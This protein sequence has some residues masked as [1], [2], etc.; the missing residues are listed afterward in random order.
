MTEKI[1]KELDDY[2][3]KL[4]GNS[5]EGMNK[6]Y[7]YIQ[8]TDMLLAMEKI[9]PGM[10]IGMEDEESLLHVKKAYL[11]KEEIPEK[12]PSK[13]TTQVAT[14]YMKWQFWDTISHDSSPL[15]DGSIRASDKDLLE[16]A[17]FST[18]HPMDKW[19]D[20]FI[21]RSDKAFRLET[22]RIRDDQIASQIN[23]TVWVPKY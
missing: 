12:G 6:I 2:A 17:M 18:D 3:F 7:P 8:N 10:V 20:A 11:I 22:G 19:F 21:L 23:E 1:L 13:Y 14:T 4:P 15:M 5:T 16:D 9:I